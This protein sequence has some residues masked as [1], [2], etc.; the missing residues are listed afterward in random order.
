MEISSRTTEGLPNQCP[1]CGKQVW[2]VPSV[3]P[4]DA[5]CP[6][7]GSTVWFSNAPGTVPDV[8]RQLQERGA[9]VETDDE[10]QIHSIRLV[11]RIYTDAA[12]ELLGKLTGVRTLDVSRTGI[13]PAGIARLQS[14][15]PDTK[16]AAERNA[17]DNASP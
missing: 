4:G 11:G 16:I 5:T 2:I 13:T 14:L 1:T 3:P 6:H 17:A 12:V 9:I 8:L 15:L 10:D 7:C